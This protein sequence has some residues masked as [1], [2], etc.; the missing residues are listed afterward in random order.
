VQKIHIPN[1]DKL[2]TVYNLNVIISV[3]FRVNSKKD[4]SF[5]ICANNTLKEYL[6]KTSLNA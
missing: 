4:T 1:S 5:R 6:I 3:G 2:V